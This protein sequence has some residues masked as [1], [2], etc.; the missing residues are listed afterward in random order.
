MKRL[1]ILLPWFSFFLREK[2]V[3]GYTCLVLQITIIGWPVASLWSLITLVASGEKAKN[4]KII[5]SLHPSFYTSETAM[6]NI[7]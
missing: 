7:A 4:N 2:Y 1:A 5:Q 6:R 3:Q